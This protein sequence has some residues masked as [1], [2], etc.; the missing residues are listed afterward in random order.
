LELWFLPKKPRPP[1]SPPPPLSWP[2]FGVKK[3]KGK[4]KKKKKERERKEDSLFKN[5][6]RDAVQ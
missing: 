1:T 4:G 2:L 5:G 6:G 3:K